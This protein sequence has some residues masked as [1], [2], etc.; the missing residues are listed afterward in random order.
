MKNITNLAKRIIASTLMFGAFSTPA[1]FAQTILVSDTFALNGTTRV[2]GGD[3]FG[4]PPEYE[5]GNE[6]WNTE[7][8]RF[9]SNGGITVP[10]AGNFSASTR[11]GFSTPLDNILT[12]SISMTVATTDWVGSGFYQSSNPST[13]LIS[14]GLLWALIR[15]SGEWTIFANGTS[16]EL[17]SGTIASLDASEP[18]TFS[19]SYDTTNQTARAFTIIGSTETNLIT[20]NDGWFATGLIDGTSTTAAGFRINANGST[21]ADTALVGNFVV[22]AVPEPAAV[23]LI[24]GSLAFAGFEALRR[25]RR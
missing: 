23:T 10:N 18:F 14:G 2:A 13:S 12:V 25:K 6:T 16:V 15:P 5:L 21:V 22:T 8:A 9:G 17:A 1:T 20:S 19:L 4:L 3:L 7:Y 24:L 11:I